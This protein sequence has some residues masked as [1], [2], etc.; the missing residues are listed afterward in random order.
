MENIALLLPTRQRPEMLMRL[1]ESAMDLAAHPEHVRLVA[2]IDDDDHSYDELIESPPP[3]TIFIIGPR[4]TI[5]KCWNL[6]HERIKDEATIFHHCGDDI[7]FRTQDWDKT[8]RNLFGEYPDKIVFAYGNDGSTESNNY[9]FGT[10][11]FI[12]KNWTDTVGYFVPPYFESDYNDTWLNEVAKAIGRHRHIDIM[13]EHLHFS[14][15]KMEADQN[16]RDRLERHEQQNPGEVYSG[17]S[18]RIRR[19]DDAEKLRQFM[20]NYK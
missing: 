3:R 6:C 7:V 18:M 15:G 20:E 16:T 17:R 5:S 13:T 10:H 4:M 14:L 9:E 8:V 12:H 1:Y 11:G 19:A 2:Y